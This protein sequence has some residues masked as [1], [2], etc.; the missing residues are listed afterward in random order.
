MK[1]SEF[2][3]AHEGDEISATLT[4]RLS[5]DKCDPRYSVMNMQ[6]GGT[7]GSFGYFIMNEHGKSADLRSKIIKVDL[8]T[9]DIVAVGHDLYLGHANDI[10]YDAEGGRLV[11]AHC[12]PQRDKISFIDP[13]TLTLI[14]ERIVPTGGQYAIAYSATRG[15]YAI[16]KSL[17]YDIGILD[18]DFNLLESYQGERGYVKQGME[19]DEEYIYFLQS[20]VGFN[21][22]VYYDWSGNRRGSI[23]LPIAD[24]GEHLFIRGD[25]LIIGFNNGKDKSGDIYEV[26]LG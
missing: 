26:T 7:D 2:I 18:G 4:K 16:G 25:R 14:E 24:E 23:T 11:V 15:R 9:W 1:I 20:T 17:T 10:A 21:V 3:K 19:C 8:D 12:Q 5:I 6:G 13:E 22:I